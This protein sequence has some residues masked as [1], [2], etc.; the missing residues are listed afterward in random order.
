MVLEQS[1]VE[2]HFPLLTSLTYLSD[3]VLTTTFVNDTGFK[4]WEVLSPIIFVDWNY[5]MFAFFHASPNIPIHKNAWKKS[6]EVHSTDFSLD[7]YSL[8]TQG[9][10]PSKPNALFRP[11]S[12]N[13][14]FSTFVLRHPCTLF[15]SEMRIVTGSL[16]T[17]FAQIQFGMFIQ[18]YT[19]FLFSESVLH[20]Q[21]LQF[22]LYLQFAFKNFIE[23]DWFCFTFVNS[24]RLTFCLSFHY[25]VVVSCWY[26]WYVRRFGLSLY[27]FNIFVFCP[28][29]LSLSVESVLFSSSASLSWYNFY[30]TLIY[31]TKFGIHLIDFLA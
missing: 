2:H 30:C 31:I 12:L 16:Q 6:V 29:A 22:I 20:F 15:F 17:H 21:S 14:F 24:L 28:Q 7:V 11:Y 5:C 8:K 1:L 10:I 27:W 13:I 9:E 23:Q 4:L 19:H 18:G 3:N 26:C 25:L